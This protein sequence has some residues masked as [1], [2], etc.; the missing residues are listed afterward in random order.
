MSAISRRRTVV[1]IC[2]HTLFEPDID[3]GWIVVDAGAHRGDFARTLA[4]RYG[5]RCYAIEASPSLFSEL[6]ATGRV[7][8]FHYAVWWS[9]GEIEF[10][11]RENPE[12]SGVIGD[13]RGVVAR[14]RVPSIDLETFAHRYGLPRIDLLKLD[15]EGAEVCALGAVSDEF[16]RG[17]AQ[18]TVEFH[19]FN[20]LVR[21]SDIDAIRERLGKLGFICIRFSLRSHLNVLFLNAQRTGANRTTRWGLRGLPLYLGLL[22]ALGSPRGRLEPAAS[23]P[24]Q[25]SA[26]EALSRRAHAADDELPT[27]SFVIPVRDDAARLQVCLDSIARGDYP[28]HLVDVVVVDNGSIDG[29]DQVAQAAGARVL[30][31][32]GRRPSELRNDGAAFAH[33]RIVALVDADHEI[34]RGWARAA[35]DVLANRQIAAAGD[36]Y[37]PTTSGTWVQRAYDAFRY[38]R[39]GCHD[40]EWLASGNLAVRRECFDEIDGFDESLDTCEDV[41]LCQ[42]LR[43]RGYRIA[44]DDRLKSVHFGDPQTLGTLFRTELWR[45]RDNVRASLRGPLTLR[46]VPSVLI[47]MVNLGAL[48]LGILGML[49]VPYGGGRML[50]AAGVTIGAVSALRA[51]RMMARQTRFGAI[52]ALGA[53]AV[54]CVY[55]VARAL[56]LVIRAPHHRTRQAGGVAV[57]Q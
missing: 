27:V 53:F 30:R 49:T 33:G 55:D 8:K 34:D 6:A 14:Q 51:A 50:L 19:D 41:D 2:G 16:L 23:R 42:R 48:G 57:S 5:C 46:S 39:P 45:G 4:E 12:T 35:V 43:M 11:I 56:A 54:A 10:N 1:T 20:G 7:K 28:S 24:P 32:P 18:I 38:R 37:S 40:V 21:A 31:R 36:W 3:A 15:I 44:S 13:G 52:D 22:R 26:G 25:E 29:S 17:I 47:P 9:E